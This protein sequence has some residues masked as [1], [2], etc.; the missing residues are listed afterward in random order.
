MLPDPLSEG[1]VPT[2]TRV[3]EFI[4]T[5]LGPLFIQIVKD[6]AANAV[7]ATKI[8]RIIIISDETVL[9][10]SNPPTVNLLLG[11]LEFRYNFY[12]NV[13][14]DGGHYPTVKRNT[15]ETPQLTEKIIM[16]VVNEVPPEKVDPKFPIF[17]SVAIVCM[18]VQVC[19][20]VVMFL[21]GLSQ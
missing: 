7:I 2:L 20:G 17:V 12:C 13:G 6:P 19:F 14:K 4:E 9:S 15:A 18:L 10:S 11:E 1:L 5:I 8:N 16:N 21:L 3:S